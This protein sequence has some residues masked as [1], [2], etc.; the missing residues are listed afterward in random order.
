MEK[1][2]LRN[3]V[4]GIL[5]LIAALVSI[6]M[7][8]IRQLFIVLNADRQ[9]LSSE[10]L[11]SLWINTISTTIVTLIT[12]SPAIVLAVFL[13]LRKRGTALV[14]TSIIALV[15]TIFNTG[16][17]LLGCI[18]NSTMIL[19]HL[20][21]MILVD[22]LFLILVVNTSKEPYGGFAKLWFLPG[23]IYCV[24]MVVYVIYIFLYNRSFYPGIGAAE[25]L[26]IVA[27]AL[28]GNLPALLLR[29]AGYFLASHWL[30]NPY[31]KGYQPQ[32]AQP[33]YQQYQ[34]PAQPQYDEQTM[35]ALNYYKWQYESG[36]ITW[37]QYN[38]AIQPY[39]QK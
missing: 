39:I 15:A 16:L 20:P 23:T 19:F 6:A 25:L 24:Y 34:Q 10:L 30:S 32:Q 21:I 22:A 1:K 28:L 31:K 37:E 9:G 11:Q 33:Q 13:A 5:L 26:T 27:P 8:M 3:C 29:G 17:T 38:A 2:N 18:I 35:Q 4:G 7:P 36:A 14:V 12:S